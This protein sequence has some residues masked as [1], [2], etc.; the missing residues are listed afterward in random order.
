LASGP[1]VSVW[2]HTWTL[3]LPLLVGTVFATFGMLAAGN[4][5][6]GIVKLMGLPHAVGIGLPTVAMAHALLSNANGYVEVTL[7]ATPLSYVWMCSTSA[8]CCTMVIIDLWDT[9]E[10]FVLRNR[11]V[12]RSQ[13]KVESYLKK[14]MLPDGTTNVQWLM[15]R[16]TVVNKFCNEYGFLNP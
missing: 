13:Q 8:F 5:Y 7:D 9:F 12:T 4:D 16:G 14:G 15:K 11:K 2:E 1:F 10:W 6:D 3:P